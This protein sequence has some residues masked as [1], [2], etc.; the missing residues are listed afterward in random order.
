ML[1]PVM[2]AGLLY[3]LHLRSIY[4]YKTKL[5]RRSFQ[6]QKRCYVDTLCL[7]LDYTIL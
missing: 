3:Q 7:T 4:L 6:Q 5:I 1:F 2:L